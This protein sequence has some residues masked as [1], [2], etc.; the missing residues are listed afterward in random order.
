MLFSLALSLQKVSPKRCGL[1]LGAK[2]PRPRPHL[3]LFKRESDLP[4]SLSCGCFACFHCT[5]TTFTHDPVTSRD[6][7][8]T[9]CVVSGRSG[10]LPRPLPLPPLPPSSLP[11]PPPPST[12]RSIGNGSN[13]NATTSSSVA[14]QQRPSSSNRQHQT[15]LFAA[16]S[17][18]H[19]TATTASALSAQ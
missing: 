16:Q 18:C 8:T 19:R 4:T 3:Y 1:G 5:A 9:I 12:L 15:T 11:T 10:S 14:A 13:N 2:W 6:A 7:T 17:L